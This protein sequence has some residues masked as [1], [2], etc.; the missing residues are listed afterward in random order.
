MTKG[1]NDPQIGRDERLTSEGREPDEPHCRVCGRLMI[2]HHTHACR[3][4]RRDKPSDWIAPK[5]MP[6]V[7]RK[8]RPKRG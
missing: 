8:R 3:T 1:N 2:E 6:I 7:V 5:P 4:C